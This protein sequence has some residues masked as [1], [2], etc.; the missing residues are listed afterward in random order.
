MND[1]QFMKILNNSLVG[2]EPESVDVPSRPHVWVVGLPRSGTTLTMQLL[3]QHLQVGYVDNIMARFWRAP[4]TGARLSEIILGD[5]RSVSYAS[6]H[7]STSDPGSPHEFSYFWHDLFGLE[8]HKKI[9]LKTIRENTDWEQVRKKLN[10]IASIKKSPMVY[11][12]LWPA[13]FYEEFFS[14]FPAS[15]YIMI[16]RPAL[17]VAA[18]LT[19]AR[20]QYYGD[21]N[22]WWSMTFEGYEEYL[23]LHYSD[24]I[25]IQLSELSKLYFR[26]LEQTK[27]VRVLDTSYKELCEAP[28]KFLN[29]VCGQLE[30]LCNQ[31]PIIKGNIPECFA[32][33]ETYG[34]DDKTLSELSASLDRYF[35]DHAE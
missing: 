2:L 8:D 25:A 34:V 4:C 35:P 32:P 15:L 30:V 18:S 29:D 6:N 13:Y 12:A 5:E 11:K 3:C 20:E 10:A 28:Q 27:R 14:M 19:R 26:P 16:R 22:T 9:D 21:R 31:R 33:R 24:Q 1:L 17:E 7:G 23:A